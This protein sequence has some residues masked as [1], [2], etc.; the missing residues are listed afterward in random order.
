MRTSLQIWLFA[1][2]L[3]AAGLGLFTRSNA[4]PFYYH[5]DEPVKVKQIQTAHWNF[6]HPMLMLT[7]A[8]LAVNGIG[9]EAA[10]P[11]RVVEV[12]RWVSAG[13]AAAA[14]ALLAALA[15]KI[16]GRFAGISAGLLLLTN[17]QLFE[18]AHYF[19]EDTALLF[20]TSAWLLALALYAKRPDWTTAAGVGV[21][22]ALALSG[23]YVGIFAPLLS[24]L[25]IP[26]YAQPGRR[27]ALLGGFLAA[28][29]AVFALVNLPLLLQM[30]TF[31]SSFH[32]EVGLVLHGQRGM[33]RSVPHTVYLTAFRDNVPFG[34]WPFLGIAL[35]HFWTRR[36]NRNALG[37]V[38][39]FLPL[40][41]MALL[42]FAPKTHDRY[43]LPATGLFV[44]AAALGAGQLALRPGWH[45][46]VPA[47]MACA[48][49]LQI[50]GIPKHDLWSYYRAFQ[51]DDRAELTAWLNT[52]QPAAVIAQDQRTLL[53]TSQEKRFLPYQ[54]VLSARVIG[55]PLDKL[56]DLA[57]LRACGVTLVALC[58][59]DFGGYEV[60]S[61]RPQSGGEEAWRKTGALYRALR[62]NRKPLW[63]R[64]RGR[65]AYL[66]PGLMVYDLPP[67]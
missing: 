24:L 8:R 34:L 44:C 58:Q 66:H 31:E 27:G 29:A 40:A 19:K 43:F 14:V 63:E 49:A 28:L 1:A 30:G 18:L 38:L 25:L 50:A 26:H 53:P 20:G 64:P 4:F 51:T 56:A 45:K 32:R 21:G 36:G 60:K 15:W 62:E 16:G 13:F 42:S 5:P 39:L 3:F 37:A 55:E 7:T 52:N 35:A 48:L 41:Y 33:T 10:N 9:A 47:L 67:E 6:N 65:V 2:F 59:G 22:A 46:A 17:H 11:Q 23:K 61:L 57:A 12:G 54:P